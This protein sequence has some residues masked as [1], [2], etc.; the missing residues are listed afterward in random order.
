MESIS[1]SIFT[2]SRSC[3]EMI[4]FET[5]IELDRSRSLKE[6]S[7]RLSLLC[8]SMMNYSMADE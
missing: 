5:K 8:S 7:S 2:T 3:N 1:A 4:S 6:H